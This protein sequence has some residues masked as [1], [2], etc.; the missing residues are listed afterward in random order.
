MTESNQRKIVYLAGFLFSLSLALTSYVNSTLL[1]SVIGP[2]YV[3][4][5]YIL[6][7][8]IT[9]LFLFEIPRLLSRIGNR[10]T[11]LITSLLSGLS[12]LALA[13]ASGALAII[14]AFIIYFLCTT[15]VNT[16]LDIF[17]E[18][19]STGHS[20]G[21]YR[22]LY[23]VICNVAWVIAQALSGDIIGSGT[24]RSIFVAAGV[25]MFSVTLVFL[26][27][28][29]EFQDPAYD[30][31]P[32][33]RTVT[34]FFKNRSLSRIYVINFILKFFYAWMIIYTPIYL[35]RYIGLS[36]EQI[37]IVFTVML[38]P[39]VLVEFPLGQMSDRIGEKK[40]LVLGFLIAAGTTALLPFINS[41]GVAIWAIVLFAS[42]VGAA[43][44]EVMSESYFF[45][46]VNERNDDE[47]GLFRNTGP[48]SYVIAPLIAI[49]VLVLVPSFKEI[50]FVLSAILM[51]GFFMAL[52]LRDVK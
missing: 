5:I 28:M 4:L 41:P 38:L 37:G 26:F 1:E 42:R 17:L 3:G 22:G 32:I 39:F 20:I 29:R 45:K 30:D 10:K 31:F 13:R 46:S 16:S 43:M 27:T 47:I 50:F 12:F 11:V 19:Y 9:I 8:S 35:N 21:K 23:L 24:L 18:H 34:T 25:F 51:V 49:P 48:L 2:K 15:F 6:A 36:W 7:S 52:R 33:L 40:F 44:I 14:L